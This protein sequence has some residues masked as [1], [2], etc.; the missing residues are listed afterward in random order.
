[1]EYGINIKLLEKNVCK[2]DNSMTQTSFRCGC[3]C[4]ALPRLG[5]FPLQATLG[6]FVLVALATL[7]D[8]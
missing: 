2:I 6:A 7:V 5:G 1:M 3:G 8:T 4:G